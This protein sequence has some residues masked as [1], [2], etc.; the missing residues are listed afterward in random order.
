MRWNGYNA[1][2]VKVDVWHSVIWFISIL[3]NFHNL[4]CGDSPSYVRTNTWKPSHS[5]R[6]TAGQTTNLYSLMYKQI[7]HKEN[8]A[9]RTDPL[10]SKLA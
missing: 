10:P 5:D 1:Y 7:G 4:Q 6:D 9:Y 3:C 8:S 2:V